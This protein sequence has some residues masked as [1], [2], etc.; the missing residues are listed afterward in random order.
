MVNRGVIPQQLTA[1]FRKAAALR[2]K[3]RGSREFP[4]HTNPVNG[5]TVS[6]SATS[7]GGGGGSGSADGGTISWMASMGQGSSPSTAQNFAIG[8]SS[9]NALTSFASS[10]P[11]V[12]VPMTLSN[13]TART[14]AT[15]NTS[16]QMSQQQQQALL[17]GHYAPHFA[18]QGG[19]IATVQ[20][21]GNATLLSHRYKTVT[22]QQPSSAVAVGP[23]KSN[24]AHSMSMNAN[25]M[26]SALNAAPLGGGLPASV[27]TGSLSTQTHYGSQGN[28]L[29]G[30]QQQQQHQQLSQQQSSQFRGRSDTSLSMLGHTSSESNSGGSS[31]FGSVG[32]LP[33]DSSPIMQ[34]RSNRSRSGLDLG[35]SSVGVDVERLDS[36]DRILNHSFMSGGLGGGGGGPHDGFFSFSSSVNG[37]STQGGGG[38]GIPS[39]SP[40]SKLSSQGQSAVGGGGGGGIQM[41]GIG[42][43]S[44]SFSR[45]SFGGLVG[46]SSQA[47]HQSSSSSHQ[48]H[49]QHQQLQLQNPAASSRLLSSSIVLG[50][51]DQVGD[52]R[53]Q[54]QQ[55]LYYQQQSQQ[56]QAQLQREQQQYLQ[57]QQQQQQ[58]QFR[59]NMQQQQQFEGGSPR[60]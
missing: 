40:H 18:T 20:S 35:E 5:S 12:S 3:R 50:S 10:H 1:K 31:P 23:S 55:Q 19:Q 57:E 32:R 15:G 21:Q 30:Q 6:A 14:S 39:M 7:A 33:L 13:R 52:Q 4:Q 42:L 34:T 27:S 37:S 24:L 47:L 43:Q 45:N 53:L 44:S 22:L 56:A 16:T 11:G 54:T 28:L 41:D 9:V 58:Q 59:H 26:G 8:G 49:S 36:L 29:Y 48:M 2:N 25:S 60:W 46:D 51:Q 38:D 17:R